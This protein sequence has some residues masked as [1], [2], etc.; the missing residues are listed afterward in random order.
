MPAVP[1]RRRLFD[2][3]SEYVAVRPAGA[4][5]AA[6]AYD[7]LGPGMNIGGG[8]RPE[9]V[10][11]IHISADYFKVF[12]GGM[13]LGRTF[14]AEEDVPGGP[15]LVILSHRLWS[16]HFGSDFNIAGRSI[17]INGDPHTVVGVVAQGFRAS[18]DADI[19]IPLKADPTSTNHGNFL[20]VAARLKPG[21]SIEQARAELNVVGERFRQ[22]KPTLDG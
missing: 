2:V 17:T 20:N 18:P 22:G 3:D 6:T 11:G 12:G 5:A 13:T 19:F 8:D 7:F 1:K 21:V 10:R 4:F 14:S 16:S 9:Q 15:N